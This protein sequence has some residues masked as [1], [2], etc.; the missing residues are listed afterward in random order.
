MQDRYPERKWIKKLAMNVLS[1]IWGAIAVCALKLR[2]M[3]EGPE[4]TSCLLN[5]I[6]TVLFV[7]GGTEGF[8]S[9]VKYAEHAKNNS[10]TPPTIG[11]L[12]G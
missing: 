12:Q 10:K 3:G 8:N 11:K 6:I 7:S 2:L 4:S 5:Y 1:V 9:L